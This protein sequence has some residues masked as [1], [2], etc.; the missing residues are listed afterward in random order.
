MDVHNTEEKFWVYDLCALIRQINF[1][2]YGDISSGSR[3]NAVTRLILL[4]FIIMYICKYKYAVMFLAI[5]LTFLIVVHF[6][7]NRNIMNR[8]ITTKEN[9]ETL[10]LYDN[11]M[12]SMKTNSIDYS[13]N[14]HAYNKLG[15]TYGYEYDPINLKQNTLD[16]SVLTPNTQVDKEAGIQYYTPNHGINKNMFIEPVIIPRSHDRE[17]WSYPSTYPSGMNNVT[18]QDTTE[19]NN[20]PNGVN[21]YALY[22]GGEV[23]YTRDNRSIYSNEG[24]WIQTGENPM[25]TLDKMEKQSEEES[26]LLNEKKKLEEEK[27]AFEQMRFEYERKRLENEMRQ[28][29]QFANNQ[30]KKNNIA[31]KYVNNDM[32]NSKSSNGVTNINNILKGP[33]PLK[34]NGA[35]YYALDQTA[36]LKN[37]YGKQ[38]VTTIDSVMSKQG[39]ANFMIEPSPT[40]TY[41]DSY[42]NEP[43]RRIYMQDIQP[44]VYSYSMEQEPINNNIGISFT[45]Q[46]PP[47][48][49]DQVYNEN[50]QSYPLY[51]RVD[52]QLVRD[53]G[54]AGQMYEQPERG[55]W[56]AKYAEWNPPAGT[57]NFEDIYDPRFTSYGDPYRSYT[58]VNLG[59]VQYYYSD[60]DAYRRPNFIIRSKIDFVDFHDPMGKE[61]AYYERYSNLQDVKDIAQNRFDADQ[62]SFREDLMGLQM[63]KR[64]SEMWQLREAPLSKA[65]H[66]HAS[67]YGPGI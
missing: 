8:I 46:V 43:S 57:I 15:R 66:T 38:N 55:P 42:F 25:L 44:N 16:P 11:K 17:F 52:P 39:D 29:T 12:Q 18:F 24:S 41:T 58:D 19:A 14:N 36:S 2:P 56:S 37:K 60:V 21:N 23:P 35:D 7:Y 3:L 20:F 31:T 49:R 53:D 54:T 4:I 62:L 27:K 10:S 6:C 32:Q 63:Q 47:R 59:Q 45:P 1:I 61:K 33:G 48:F 40:Y 51:T 22:K 34:S 9:F 67:T 13:Y 5:S 30:I 64:N 65:N 26:K 50:G 28:P